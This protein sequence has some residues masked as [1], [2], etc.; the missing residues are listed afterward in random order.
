MTTHRPGQWP[1]A[2]P[3][4]LGP[5][6]AAPAS[7]QQAQAAPRAEVHVPEVRLVITIDLTG[8]YASSREVSADLHKQTRYSTDCHTAIVHV[9]KDALRC[10]AGLGHAIAAQFFLSARTVEIH[11][12]AD[13]LGAGLASVVQQHLRHFAADHAQMLANLRPTG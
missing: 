9:G 5:V 10:H 11:V 2:N 12:P 6:P 8:P 1:V 4:P 7:E 3:V 13:P